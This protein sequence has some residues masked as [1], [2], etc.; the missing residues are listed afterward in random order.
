MRSRLGTAAHFC[1]VVVLNLS[2]C[3]AKREQLDDRF[4]G[5]LPESQGQNRALIVLYVPY[6]LDS[7]RPALPSEDLGSFDARIRTMGSLM[8]QCSP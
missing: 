5:L 2:R 7:G 1:G 4:P 8:K 3:R 6:S